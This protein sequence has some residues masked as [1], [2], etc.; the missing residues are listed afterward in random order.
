M[1]KF[2]E[3]NLISLAKS[4]NS[5]LYVVGGAVRNFLIDKSYSLDVDLA[6]AIP[7]EELSEKL[8]QFGFT[9]V[10]EYKRTGTVVF[11]GEDRKYEYTAFRR[12]KYSKGGEHTPIETEFTLDILEDAKRRDFKC[13]AVYYDIANGKIV[14]V[15]GGV[16]DI[17]NKVLDT[18]DLPE[19]VFGSDGLRLM[20]LARFAGEL[21]FKPTL[22]VMG[23]AT[24]FASNIKDISPERIYA[25]L[26]RIL[27]S[28]EKYP[29]SDKEGHYTGL[30]ILDHTRV[31]DYVFPEL[32]QGRGMAQ[33]ADFHKY[34]VLEHSLRAVLH[35]NY[36][37]RLSSLLHDVAKP[38]CFKR[39][40]MYYRHDVEGERMAED[41]LRRLKA[42]N[43]TIKKVK[44]LVKAHMVDLDCSM[45]ESKV[46]L[47][48]VRNFNLLKELLYVKQADYRASLEN[49]STSPT[50]I[51]WGKI[52]WEMCKNGVPFTL[53]DLKISAEDL[54]ALGFKGQEIGKELKK[55]WEFA[56]V[57]D[58][59]ND[60]DKLLKIAKDDLA[61]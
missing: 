57:N 59:A 34:D 33:R 45:R 17:K 22:E 48:M 8:K 54:I 50:L 12:E 30:K 58:G 16:K 42:D 61:K 6:A 55:L 35:S 14:D 53:K 28:D 52:Y 47:F 11:R 51:K 31:L 19:K 41:I 38:Y 13:N 7:T 23:A 18:V 40:G 2:F 49:D 36:S 26:L 43:A 27:H 46:R 9:I 60:K 3:K 10:A 29:F 1:K 5:P 32:T 15:L 56:V 21:N 20:R 39:D 4:L 24:K 37:V 25:E 44:F